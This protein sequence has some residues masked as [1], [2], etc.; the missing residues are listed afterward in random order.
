MCL[1]K[2]LYTVYTWPVLDTTEVHNHV[3]NILKQIGC[4]SLQIYYRIIYK[5]KVSCGIGE[6]LEGINKFHSRKPTLK[7]DC[8]HIYCAIVLTK[9]RHVEALLVKSGLG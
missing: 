7:Q 3:M 2:V 6:R 4:L 9:K 5:S 1:K 8:Q